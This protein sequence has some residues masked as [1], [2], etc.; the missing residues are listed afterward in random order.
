MSDYNK[1]VD[2]SQNPDPFATENLDKLR[3]SQDFAGVAKVKP[4]LTNIR[5][6]KPHR[7]EF[8]RVRSGVENQFHTGCFVDK[9]TREVY[10]V[11]PNLWHLLAGDVTPT[12][13]VVCKARNCDIPFLWPLTVPDSEGRSNRWHDSAIEAAHLAES[14]WLKVVADMSAGLY[15]PMV[16]LGNLAEPDWSDVPMMHELLRLAFKGRFIDS[17]DHPVLRRLRGEN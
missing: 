5:C 13:L 15:V 9:E 3:L 8:V 1:N 14:Q 6:R 16:A 10:L 2:A 12:M 17:E 11:S 7:Q 4:A